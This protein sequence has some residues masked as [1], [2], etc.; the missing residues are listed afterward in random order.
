MNLSWRPIGRRRDGLVVRDDRGSMSMVMIVVIVGLGLAALVVPIVVTQTHATSHTD[1]RVQALHQAESGVDAMLGRLRDATA[2]GVSGEFDLLPCFEPITG[3]PLT[4]REPDSSTTG[5]D[6]T[7]QYFTSDPVQPR[8]SP[9]ALPVA[10]SCTPGA[11]PS[12][13]PNFARITSIGANTTGGKTATRTLRTTYAFSTA[14]T[15][16][17]NSPNV[18]L[19]GGQIRLNPRNTLAE[20]Q[21]LDA[22]P[23]P[24]T[25]PVLTVQACAALTSPAT[26]AANAQLF[27]YNWDLSLR[28]VQ[29]ISAAAPF[30]L[31]VNSVQPTST[32]T[33][34]PCASTGQATYQQQWSLDDKGAFVQTRPDTS[35]VCLAVPVGFTTVGTKACPA[36]Y[37]SAASWLPTPLVGS[38]AAGATA[39]QLV[40]LGQFG[41]C[42]QVTNEIA[43]SAAPNPFLILYPCKQYPRATPV[44]WFQNFTYSST[45]QHWTTTNTSGVKYCLTS[46]TGPKPYVTVKLCATVDPLQQWTDYG[47]ALADQAN[48]GQWLDK[49]YT[50]RDVNDLCLSLSPTAKTDLGVDA[51]WFV[52]A[53]SGQQYS[54]IT[55]ET[56]DGSARQKWNSSESRSSVK[57][58][59]EK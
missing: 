58:T 3:D 31:C 43:P 41:R 30:G 20:T 8:G 36:T 10:M 4:W 28:L 50:I 32:V 19:T 21:C 33:L 53:S 51:D 55:A 39:G 1:S 46:T 44:D 15:V 26:V 16:G 24:A 14:N 18:N 5:Y 22:G 29:S 12:A 48:A 37:D 6:V 25:N 27:F 56:C 45:T 47:A 35:R 7:L 54:K 57:D 13:L 2:D 42:V 59:S 23:N 17:V 49:A 40:N 34:Q 11:G 38:G 9:A 52:D